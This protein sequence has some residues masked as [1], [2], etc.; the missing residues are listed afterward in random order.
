[1]LLKNLQFTILSPHFFLC[2][3]AQTDTRTPMNRFF[4]NSEQLDWDINWSEGNEPFPITGQPGLVVFPALA[5]K[6]QN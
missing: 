2:C 3:S 1:M 6:L 4:Y 5:N